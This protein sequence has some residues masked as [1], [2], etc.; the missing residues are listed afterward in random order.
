MNLLILHEISYKA[1]LVTTKKKYKEFEAWLSQILQ[2]YK[3]AAVEHTARVHL[4]RL[5]EQFSV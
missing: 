1:S 4:F 3:D 2:D 5:R